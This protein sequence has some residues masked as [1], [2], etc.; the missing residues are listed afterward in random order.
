M[1]PCESW[2]TKFDNTSDRATVF[3]K[4][5]GA[6]IPQITL[7]PISV[8]LAAVYVVELDKLRLD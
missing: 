3:A 1:I 8:N 7:V 6:P 4:S 5:S 2:P